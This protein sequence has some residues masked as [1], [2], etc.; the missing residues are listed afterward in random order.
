MCLYWSHSLTRFTY[1]LTP[2]LLNVFWVL[3]GTDGDS[4]CARKFS[5]Y[6]VVV[7]KDGIK[8]RLDG[9]EKKKHS[10]GISR[11]IPRQFLLFTQFTPVSCHFTP[12]SRQFTS[13]S[14]SL[15]LHFTLNG[16]VC[17]NKKW[18]GCCVLSLLK[19]AYTFI[20][21]F[22]GFFTRHSVF[23]TYFCVTFFVVFNDYDV[24]WL[25][26]IGSLIIIVILFVD[27]LLIILI[28]FIVT[29]QIIWIWLLYEYIILVTELSTW[30]H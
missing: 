12:H 13:L 5:L 8:I 20:V 23:H 27:V 19:A 7:S 11:S 14:L 3:I 6:G 16:D 4:L 9:E 21:R 1:L 18:H 26:G 30:M 15:A 2:T 17:E 10:F 28:V 24:V 22:F 29:C 25:L